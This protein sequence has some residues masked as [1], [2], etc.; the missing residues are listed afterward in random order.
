MTIEKILECQK[1]QPNSRNGHLNSTLPVKSG[2]YVETTGKNL[3]E[4]LQIGPDSPYPKAS[5]L[6][7]KQFKL[8]LNKTH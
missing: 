5:T 8:Q 1:P 7:P 2:S 3:L 6:G 4:H